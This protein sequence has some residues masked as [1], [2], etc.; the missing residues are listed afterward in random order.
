MIPVPDRMKH[1]ERDDR[2]YPIPFIV[3]RDTLN[4]PHFTINDNA[5]VMRCITADLCAI[6]G[7][8]LFRGRWF[9]GGPK[10][11]FHPHGAYIDPPMHHEC[12]RF[13]VQ[14]CPYLTRESYTKRLDGKT[15]D[16]A[17]MPAHHIGLQ[18][19]TMDPTRPRVFVAV[20]AVGQFLT[21]SMY[22]VPKRPYRKVE[23]WQGGKMIQELTM[24]D[25]I[26]KLKAEGRIGVRRG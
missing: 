22:L 23:V 1:L 5:K 4:Q 7:K 9:V 15:L 8:P 11:A 13:A 17:L 19:N 25:M 12:M 2:G 6:C 18:D 20:M 21:P 16:P 14:T 3:L 24:D 10:S 26:G